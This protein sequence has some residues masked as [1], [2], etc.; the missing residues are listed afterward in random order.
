M[1]VHSTTTNGVLVL[2]LDSPPVNAFGVAVLEA[3]DA[4]LAAAERDPSIVAV[5]LGGRGG[6]FSG[7]ADIRTFGKPWP[8]QKPNLRDVIAR[9]E[10]S[11]KPFYAALDGTAFGGG[12]EVALACDKRYATRSSRVGLPEINLGLLPGAGG[13]QRLPRLV[14]AA[15]ALEVVL[16]GA[17][18]D[19][20]RAAELGILE[21]VDGNVLELASVEAASA[22]GRARIRLSELPVRGGDAA[23]FAAAR[24]AQAPAERGGLAAQRCIDAVEAA[25]LLPFAGGLVRERELFEELRASAQS[26]AR[27][28]I[29]FAEREAAKIPGLDAAARAA[30]IVRACVIGSGTMGGGIAMALANGGIPVRVID[31]SPEQL[32]RGRATIAKNYASTASKGRLTQAQVDERLGRIGFETDLAAAA[33][34]ADVVIEAVFEEL[35]IKRDVFETLD[36]VCRPGTL[37]ATNTSTLD[38]DAIAAATSRP[39]DVIGLHFF[40]PANVMRLLEIVRGAATSPQAL[41]TSLALA[42]RIKKVG[43]VA[44]TCDGFIGNRMLA[45]YSREASYLIEE[46]ALPQDVDRVIR[47]FGFPMGPFAMGDLAGL[48]VGW[49][50]KKRRKAEGAYSSVRESE[51]GDRLCELGRFGQKTNAGFYR[52]EAGQ[53]TPQRDPDVEAIIV[54]E[55]ARLRLQ[56]RQVDDEEILMRCMLPLVNEGARILADGTAIRSGDIDVVWIS[57]YGFPAFR[58][59]PMHWAD[60]LGLDRVLT[61]IRT[62]EAAHGA[63]WKPAPL[64]EDLARSG[65]TFAELAPNEALR[66]KV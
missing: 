49:R 29:F 33:S 5:V 47:E 42:K 65:R 46:G 43:V 48:D 23:V 50:I 57:G 56:R 63:H 58:G 32:E 19:A 9:I 45:R 59:G 4:E 39:Q 1:D 20:T 15:A 7:G 34:D 36:R 31:A 18:V 3:L 55:S 30:P 27:I 10:A 37:L 41:A 11:S 52:Y 60:G 64:L 16:S 24:K 2:E 54:A 62:L 25:T 14:G 6:V 66:E 51:I 53:R 35:D 44:R 8:A 13:T 40:S 28:H 12:F 22:A 17:P 61:E 26:K 38:I 21:I